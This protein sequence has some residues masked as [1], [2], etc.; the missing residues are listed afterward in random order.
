VRAKPCSIVAWRWTN[1][2]GRRR[3]FKT[4]PPIFRFAMKVTIE[5]LPEIEAGLSAIAAERGLSLTKYVRVI[6]EGQ[7]PARGS[8]RLSPA[9]R[10]AT[11]RDSV[12]GLPNTPPLSD[13]A[14]SR[15]SMFDDR[16]G[17]S[18]LIRT[19]C[20]AAH[21]LTIPVTRRRLKVLPVYWPPASSCIS[22]CRT[23]QNFGMW[24]P[25]R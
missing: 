6:L 19:S 4:I 7:V 16:G 12:R 3:I 23:S 9:E 5:L 15:A 17:A 24:P 2:S 1:A 20:C 21:S 18:S 13:E 8:A 10:A 25:T 14:I 22:R 11:W